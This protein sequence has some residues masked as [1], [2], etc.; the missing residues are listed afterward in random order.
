VS[1]VSYRNPVV[2]AVPVVSV[3]P[4]FPQKSKEPR[5]AVITA[6]LTP[7]PTA[8][9]ISHDSNSL[10]DS[11]FERDPL[12]LVLAILCASVGVRFQGLQSPAVSDAPLVIFTTPFGASSA[13]SLNGFGTN[14][15]QKQV[16]NVYA[17]FGKASPYLPKQN[18]RA[19]SGG[20][21]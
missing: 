13:I 14:A 6:H 18:S 5:P 16:E 7:A 2:P 19:A 9:A 17:R 11:R 3:T 4:Q 10:I 12:L 21:R 15:L 1:S 8:S 20:A